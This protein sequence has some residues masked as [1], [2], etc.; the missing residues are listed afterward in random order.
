MA[1][2]G[3]NQANSGN[4]ELD[5]KIEQWL[6]WDKVSVYSAYQSQLVMLFV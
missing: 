5:K 3:N 1:A 4:D 2:N 6:Q